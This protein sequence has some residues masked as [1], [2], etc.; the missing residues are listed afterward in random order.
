MGRDSGNVQESGGI[1]SFRG[2]GDLLRRLPQMAGVQMVGLQGLHPP[3][4]PRLIPA[5]HG[6]A[7]IGAYN[8]GIDAVQTEEYSVSR[9]SMFQHRHINIERC[10]TRAPEGNGVVGVFLLIT[11]QRSPRTIIKDH[12]QRFVARVLDNHLAK[13][14]L[15]PLKVLRTYHSPL[16]IVHLQLILACIQPIDLFSVTLQEQEP[17]R[18]VVKVQLE[19]CVRLSHKKQTRDAGLQAGEV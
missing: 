12:H 14:I 5:T 11:F 4:P 8:L 2:G 3:R 18:E 10:R 7:G 15:A 19:G 9:N 17:R 1:R 13:Q 6:Q 16:P